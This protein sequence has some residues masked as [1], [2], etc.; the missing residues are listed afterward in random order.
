MASRDP[1]D[2]HPPTRAKWFRMKRICEAAGVRVF[3][4]A[5]LRLPAE[6]QETYRQG[7]DKPGRVVTNAQAWESW[8]QPW[9]EGKALAFDIAFRPEHDP[10]GVT[11]DG[12]WEFVGTVGEFVGLKWGGR[13]NHPDR[14]HF[15]DSNGRTLATLRQA[16]GRQIG[17]V[18]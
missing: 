17:A 3:L 14:P 1:N 5:T 9:V 11:W 6:Q 2:L 18:A 4:T 10:T 16:H 15:E 12:P 13:W 8:H 7:R